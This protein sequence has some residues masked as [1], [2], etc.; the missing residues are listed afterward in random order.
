MDGQGELLVKWQAGYSVRNLLMDSQHQVI[1]SLLNRLF[2]AIRRGER[3]VVPEEVL[4]ELVRYTQIH[5]KAEEHLLEQ[6]RYPRLAE[7][8]DL[9]EGMI[10]RT[11]DL[12]DRYTPGDGELAYTILEFLK[13]WWTGHIRVEDQKYAQ[14][15]G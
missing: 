13:T 4:K 3:S 7:H 11:R 15:V 12:C 2:L 8:R 10:Q 14:V 1:F 5:F 6:C 9:H